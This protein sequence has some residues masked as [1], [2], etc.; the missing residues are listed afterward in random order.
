MMFF[1]PYYINCLYFISQHFYHLNVDY[2]VVCDDGDGD[3][4]GDGDD[5][6]DDDDGDD[7][8]DDVLDDCVL[9]EHGH[10]MDDCC[11]VGAVVQTHGEENTICR[12][13]ALVMSRCR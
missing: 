8:D 13:Q 9:L 6:D 2:C 1:V 11:V 10:K 12:G 3:G 7:D 4:K 5:D